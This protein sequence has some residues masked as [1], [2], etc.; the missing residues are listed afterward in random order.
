MTRIGRRGTFVLS[1]RASLIR[2]MTPPSP[3][4]QHV[5]RLKPHYNR[6]SPAVTQA[7]KRPQVPIRY[8]AGKAQPRLKYDYLSAY[9]RTRGGCVRRIS[10]QRDTPVRYLHPRSTPPHLPI[11]HLEISRAFCLTRTEVVSYHTPS[12]LR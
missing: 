6:E 9:S 8:Q 11:S 5:C 12:S 7:K 2:F 3:T 1:K 4:E 10:A